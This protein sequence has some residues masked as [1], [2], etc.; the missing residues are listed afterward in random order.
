MVGVISNHQP[1]TG[2]PTSIGIYPS[3]LKIYCPQ[4]LNYKLLKA[5]KTQTSDVYDTSRHDNALLKQAVRFRKEGWKVETEKW[6][7][8]EF[9]SFKLTHRLDLIAAKGN[10]INIVEVKPEDHSYHDP[11]YK[12]A[13]L[14]AHAVYGDFKYYVYEYEHNN[15]VIKTEKDY[16][17]VITF[18]E[19][20]ITG[21]LVPLPVTIPSSGCNYCAYSQCKKHPEHKC[22]IFKGPFG[23]QDGCGCSL[24]CDDQ[25][26]RDLNSYF[27][28]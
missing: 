24:G 21:A 14:L 19:K 1:G 9:A 26:E 5:K 2:F 17:S 7:S 13:Q 25:I 10:Q 12:A 23:D 20:K 16:E 28:N 22:E 18:I 15:Y 4:Q 3:W 27:N 8:H 11:Q 6:I